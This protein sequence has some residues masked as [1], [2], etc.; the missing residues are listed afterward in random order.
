MSRSL[1][2][3]CATGLAW[4]VFVVYVVERAAEIAAALSQLTL[5]P[6]WLK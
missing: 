6:A 3:Y 2:L 5:L 4:L 1:A